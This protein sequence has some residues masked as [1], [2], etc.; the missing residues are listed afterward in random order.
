[1]KF[2]VGR[3]HERVH[4]LAQQVQFVNLG[5]FDGQIK[6]FATERTRR[7]LLHPFGHASG[8][9][10]MNAGG[11]FDRVGAAAIA[12]NANG[13]LGSDQDTRV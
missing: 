3:R 9:E 8:V 2:V 10:N 4:V 11:N 1:V 12:I 5:D 13:A 6:F 7:I